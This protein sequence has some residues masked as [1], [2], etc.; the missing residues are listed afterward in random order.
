[1]KLASLLKEETLKK[2]RRP[3]MNKNNPAISFYVFRKDGSRNPDILRSFLEE[4][5]LTATDAALGFFKQVD[6]SNWQLILEDEVKNKL[7]EETEAV[8]C[9][10][11]FQLRR[12]GAY[13]IARLWKEKKQKEIA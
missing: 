11:S 9:I 8:K 13:A 3:T 5:Y 6:N 4:H 1:M 12:S 2:E 7:L 10:I